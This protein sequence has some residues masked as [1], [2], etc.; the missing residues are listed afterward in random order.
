MSCTIFTIIKTYFRCCV[1]RDTPATTGGEKGDNSGP[2]IPSYYSSDGEQSPFTFDDLTRS[3]GSSASS[4]SSSI[5]EYEAR[6]SSSVYNTR[7]HIRTF[8]GGMAPYIS[9]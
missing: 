8:G 4:S 3:R 5:N 6:S 9:D 7:Q 2:F 1:T